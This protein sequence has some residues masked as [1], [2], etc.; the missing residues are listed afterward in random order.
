MYMKIITATF[1]ALLLSAC[2]G[3]IQTSTSD[4]IFDAVDGTSNLANDPDS[5]L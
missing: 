3:N 2:S 5:N 1:I 4:E